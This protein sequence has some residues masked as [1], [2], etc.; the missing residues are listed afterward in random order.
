MAVTVLI[1]VLFVSAIMEAILYYSGVVS[2]QNSKIAN[3]NIQIAN[4]NSQISNLTAQVAD[5]TNAYIVTALGATE[6][7]YNSP[8]NG[9]AQPYNHLYITGSVT[10]TGESTAYNAGLHVVAYNSTGTVEINMTVPLTNSGVEFGAAFGTDAAT[11]NFVSSNFGNS[12]FQLVTLDSGQ[13]MPI[14]LNI[15]HEG[16]VTNWTVTPVWTNFP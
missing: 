5:L 1:V 13:N 7:P 15:F 2:T 11:D 3:L 9:Y 16:T 8:H 6:I 10:N 14:M 12:S 4:L